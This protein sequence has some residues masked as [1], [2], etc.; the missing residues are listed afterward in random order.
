M[1]KIQ[2]VFLA[3]SILLM[4][5]EAILANNNFFLPGDAFFPSTLTSDDIDSLNSNPEEFRFSYSSYGGY[6]GAFC[7]FA[8]YRY[9]KV[10]AV[11]AEFA[12]NLK[13]AYR[14]VRMTES[15]VLEKT[16]VYEEELGEGEQ[17]KMVELETNGVRVMLYNKEFD[18]AK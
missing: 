4:S 12:S 11:N 8:G 16:E 6:P 10:N 14:I 18:L 2:T 15:R 13:K 7:G 17:P 9:A 5:A 1:I 3:C